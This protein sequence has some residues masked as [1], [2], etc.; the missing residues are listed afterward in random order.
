LIVLIMVILLFRSKLLRRFCP[1]LAATACLRTWIYRIFWARSAKP[2]STGST[3][4]SIYLHH[5]LIAEV[6]Q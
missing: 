5:G 6:N 3:I 1:L 4:A 2:A